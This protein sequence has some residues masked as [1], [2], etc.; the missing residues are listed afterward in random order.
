MP[1]RNPE[2]V[3][4]DVPEMHRIDRH[5]FGPAE[6]GEIGKNRQKREDDRPHDI[7]VRHGIERDA[8]E[9]A[10]RG[11]AEAVRGPG[12][13]A[14]VHAQRKEEHDE[15]EDALADVEAHVKNPFRGAG[16]YPLFRGDFQ[17]SKYTSRE[18]YRHSHCMYNT[19]GNSAGGRNNVCLFKILN[20]QGI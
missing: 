14:L 20:Y 18:F 11:V 19:V 12:V 16:D 5:G 13:R 1:H 9:H 7:D 6:D 3:A 15:N 17:V 8:P 2:A 4:P 10:G